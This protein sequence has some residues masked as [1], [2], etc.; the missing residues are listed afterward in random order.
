MKAAAK[1]LPLSHSAAAKPGLSSHSFDSSV[2]LAPH[3]SRPLTCLSLALLAGPSSVA[4]VYLF[5]MNEERSIEGCKDVCGGSFS[6][7]WWLKRIP[8]WSSRMNFAVGCPTLP[9]I[10]EKKS[11]EEMGTEATP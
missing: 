2:L 9:T 6:R 11:E 5:R 1:C 10:P 4:S 3:D 7:E 8:V